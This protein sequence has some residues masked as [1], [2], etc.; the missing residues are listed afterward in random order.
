MI[1]DFYHGSVIRDGEFFSDLK[2]G[3]SD[4]EAIWFSSDEKVSDMFC[5]NWFDEEKGEIKIIFKCE[6]KLSTIADI[7]FNCFE[8]ILEK[9]AIRDLREAIPT[10]KRMGYK[11]WKTIGSI[12]GD[13]YDDYAV[14]DDDYFKVIECKLYINGSWT[15]YMPLYE[16]EDIVNVINENKINENITIGEYEITNKEYKDL[17]FFADL[18]DIDEETLNNYLNILKIYDQKGG[19]IQRIVFSVKKPNIKNIGSCWTHINNDY[20][21]YIQSIFDFNYQEGK[22]KGGEKAW[23]ITAVTQ[24]NNIAVQNSIEQYQLN[25]EEEELT[26]ID[27]NKIKIFDIKEL[28][29]KTHINENKNPCK[30]NG[31]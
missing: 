31:R 2:I 21:N 24:P 26:I 10:L 11:G 4:W 18:C 7:D 23:L 25:P 29:L 8:E 15:D 17:L 3:H 14:F 5:D 9:W 1:G 13:V 16:A 28:N 12:G 6:I 19:N 20:N 30:T 27:I 22:I